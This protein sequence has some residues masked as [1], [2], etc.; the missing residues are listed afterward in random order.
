M[1]QLEHT[2]RKMIG[3]PKGKIGHIVSG[4]YKEEDVWHVSLK[5]GSGWCNG[6][7]EY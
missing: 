2:V 4:I 5:E 6:N 3:M 7:V 1:T